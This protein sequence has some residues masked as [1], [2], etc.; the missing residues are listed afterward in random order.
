GC[1]LRFA[2]TDD[3]DEFLRGPGWAEPERLTR[4]AELEEAWFLGLRLNAGVELGAMR[5]EFGA[6][7]VAR[8][9]DV[10]AELVSEGLIEGS[11][12]RV[13]LTLRGRLLSNEAFERFLGVSA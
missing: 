12:G 1:A 13:R 4:V 3:L 11:N 9:D 7:A 5:A 10:V 6:E 8:F 2:T